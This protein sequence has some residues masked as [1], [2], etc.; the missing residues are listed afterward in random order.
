LMPVHLMWSGGGSRR[1]PA[2]GTGAGGFTASKSGGGGITKRGIPT[3]A[4]GTANVWAAHLSPRC[5]TSAMHISLSLI[6]K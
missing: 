6:S 5:S 4:G 1:R 3:S 2:G